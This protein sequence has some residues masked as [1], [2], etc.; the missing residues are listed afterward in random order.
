MLKRYPELS[1]LESTYKTNQIKFT[2]LT[3]LGVNRLNKTFSVAFAFLQSKH[4]NEFRW[5]IGELQA[6]ITKEQSV[7]STDRDLGLLNAISAVFLSSTALIC[8]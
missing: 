6:D 4:E 2:L 1:V 8:Q 5:A 7:V 3:M